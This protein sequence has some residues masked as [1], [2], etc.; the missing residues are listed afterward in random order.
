MLNEDKTLNQ[1]VTAPLQKHFVGCCAAYLGVVR[2]KVIQNKVQI[3][4]SELVN[5]KPI[6]FSSL[7]IQVNVAG[8]N[9]KFVAIVIGSRRSPNPQLP[10]PNLIISIVL[11]I[12]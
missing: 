4:P 11:G 1:L 10:P 5:K 2:K 6:C 3:V 8:I 9:N 12:K 7:F